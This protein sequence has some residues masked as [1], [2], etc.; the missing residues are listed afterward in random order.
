MSF[1]E[2]LSRPIRLR[3]VAFAAKGAS[4]AA[5]AETVAI[6]KLAAE[7]DFSTETAGG[8]RKSEVERAIPLEP[9][10]RISRKG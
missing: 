4:E 1:I 10:N 5:R 7:T 2:A 9:Q 3:G 6:R 8:L